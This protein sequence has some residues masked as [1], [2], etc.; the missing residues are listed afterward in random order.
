[1]SSF[2]ACRFFCPALSRALLLLSLNVF[3]TLPSIL[4]GVDVK[5]EFAFLQSCIEEF[6]Q[7]RDA[8]AA[9]RSCASAFADLTGHSRLV[10][11]NVIDYFPLGYVKAVAKFVAGHEANS[12]VCEMFRVGDW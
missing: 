8:P 10:N 6:P 4:H 3:G 1:M 7:K 11:A 2:P 12:T 5:F 9:T